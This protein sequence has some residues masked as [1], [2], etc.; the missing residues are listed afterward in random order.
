MFKIFNSLNYKKCCFT[1]DEFQ[2]EVHFVNVYRTYI[3]T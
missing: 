3:W 1:D 2:T